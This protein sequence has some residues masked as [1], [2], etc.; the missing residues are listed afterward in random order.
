MNEVY[1]ELS[2]KVFRTGD[3]ATSGI[4]QGTEAVEQRGHFEK[5]L[6]GLKEVGFLCYL[7]GAG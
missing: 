3:S 2:T 4:G 5:F 6:A 1:D 7:V